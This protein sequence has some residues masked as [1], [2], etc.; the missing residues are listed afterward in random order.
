MSAIRK[1]GTSTKGKVGK[2]APARPVRPV[3]APG[4]DP[5]TPRVK[6]AKSGTSTPDYN[7]IA[8]VLNR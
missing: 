6:K 8:Q 1:D 7:T 4:Y 3:K 5:M 2:V